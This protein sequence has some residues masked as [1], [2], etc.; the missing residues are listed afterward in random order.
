FNAF[1]V[2]RPAYPVFGGG[3]GDY[4][5]E[6]KTL[7]FD[8][9]QCLSRGIVAVAFSGEQ[10]C[11]EPFTYLGWIPLTQEMTITKVENLSVKTIDGSPAFSVFQKYL[12]LHYTDHFF[13]NVLEFPF[14]IQRNGQTLARVPFFVNKDDYSIE[15]LADIYEGEKFRIGYGHPQIIIDQSVY[16]QKQMELFQPQAIFLYS[17][18]CRRFLMQKDVELETLP[19]SQIAPTAGFYTFGEFFSDGKIYSLLNSTMVA[20]GMRE[21]EP[22]KGE[23]NS[24]LNPGNWGANT[25]DPY[26]QKHAHILS[27]L[28]H[29]IKITISELESQNLKLK[30]LN[31]QKNEFLGIAAHDLRS[32]LGIIQSFS[33]LLE[34]TIDD[35]YKEYTSLITNTI[36][37]MFALLN[38]LLDISKI[39]SGNLYL[40]MERVDYISLVR[41]CMKMNGF[42]ASAKKIYINEAFEPEKLVLSIDP[43][44]IEQ[45][46]NNLLG[47][48]IKYSHHNALIIVSVFEK[49]GHV[50]TEVIDQGIGIQS[51]EIERIFHPFERTSSKPTSNESSH[52]LGLAIVKKIVEGHGG[53]VGVSS[54]W[55]KGSKF[56]FTL[57][58]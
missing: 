16:I 50:F 22:L 51:A 46:L 9:I 10:I 13:Q 11:I 7:V 6:R 57:P 42:V 48:A 47:N 43:V 17:C 8:G 53:T 30:A 28:L 27:H 5:N 39:E 58:V 23:F 18:I 45:V 31:D 19:F 55:G 32:P 40:K 37:N 21:G 26:A 24:V 54:V 1:T 12:G 2:N 15:F 29:F 49:N 52:G 20:V 33:E 34:E 14:L 25:N 56:Y 4:A 38:D 35:E 41:H 36:T 3:A 44:K